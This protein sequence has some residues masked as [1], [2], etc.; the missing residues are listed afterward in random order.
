MYQLKV[1]MVTSA[2]AFGTESFLPIDQ[3]T[4]K[5]LRVL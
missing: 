3:F 5:T 2:E 1:Q 4:N